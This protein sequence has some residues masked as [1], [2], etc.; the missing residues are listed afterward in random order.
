MKTKTKIIIFFL[1][2][3]N[4]P[5]L[6]AQTTGFNYQALIL[7]DSEIQIPGTDV[8]ANKVPLGLEE[9]ILRFT[10]TNEDNI[11]YVEE[12]TIVTDENG[13]VSLI[14]GEGN[15]ITNN[16][17]SV[18]WN[19]KVKYLSIELNIKSNNNGFVFLDT[20]KILYIP[21]P[22]NGTSNVSIVNVVGE[23]EPPYTM[24]QLIWTRSFSINEN[25]TLMIWDGINW[26]PV[27]NDFDA[28]NE[29]GLV[30]VTDNI[31]REKKYIIPAVGDQVWNATCQCLE[32][33]NG[34]N[35]TSVLSKNTTA[36]NGLYEDINTIK[37]GGALI[38][39][40]EISTSAAN[41]LAFK[42][43]EKST[44]DKDAILIAEK[45]T[46]ILRSRSFSSIVRQEQI[47]IMAIDGQL[48]F[49]TP[50]PITKEG[51][52]EVY[53]NGAR[54]AFTTI[55]ADTIELEPEAVCYLNDRIRIV[56]LY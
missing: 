13:M 46:G 5:F 17:S 43:L 54:I 30:V 37:L 51:K 10:I 39:P 40:T 14:V 15:P 29:L 24:G 20:Q 1:L 38:E 6:F 50:Q 7:N 32:I 48:Q 23:L 42:N 19:G 36:N 27:S 16:F 35:W 34:T 44:N 47:L 9:V 56:Q 25:P 45:N 21:H 33:Y 8:T 12:Q 55:N 49:N 26:L 22:S 11:E 4:A 31:D 3:L 52:I 28:T 41:T 2:I 53:R 18:N